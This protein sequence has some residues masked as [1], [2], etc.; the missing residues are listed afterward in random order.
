M[1]NLTAMAP[2]ERVYFQLENEIMEDF[3]TGDPLSVRFT[4][5]QLD[6]AISRAFSGQRIREMA[7]GILIKL[8]YL[9]EY[10]FGDRDLYGLTQKFID[11]CDR[12][13]AESV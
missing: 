9:Q 12:R 3:G 13:F 11:R 8:G 6:S 7:S 4:R 10:G 2:L 1:A 5:S